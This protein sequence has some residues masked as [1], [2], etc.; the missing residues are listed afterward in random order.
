MNFYTIEQ[1]PKNKDIFHLSDEQKQIRK[2]SKKYVYEKEFTCTKCWKTQAISEFYFKDKKT[3]RRNK[4][5]RDCQMRA[6]KVVEIGKVRFAKKILSKGFRRCSV[7]KTIK[8]IMEFAT[9]DKTFGGHTH[10][11]KECNYELSQAYIK[12]QREQVGLFYIKQYGKQKY[13]YVKFNK[14]II[15]RLRNEIIESRKPKYF[16]DGLEFLTVADF[17]RYIE[18]KYR[19]KQATTEQRIFK[20][21]TEEECK[22]QEYDM[23]SLAYTKGR[24]IVTDTVTGD[25]MEFKNTQDKKLKEMFSSSTIDLGIKTGKK[26]RITSLSKYKNPCIIK[27]AES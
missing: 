26:T 5:C 4:T 23:R 11:C 22:M 12:S 20:G 19:I 18:D 9:S 1:F 3:G 14:N 10:N 21:R 13:G 7:C 24:I 16:I 15:D 25:V 8:P 2:T 27:R 17:A 6:D